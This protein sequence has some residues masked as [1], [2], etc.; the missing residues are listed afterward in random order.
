MVGR[1]A[2]IRP[3]SKS[4]R[5]ARKAVLSLHTEDQRSQL[6]QRALYAVEHQKGLIQVHDTENET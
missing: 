6:R 2:D 5:I 1:K 4:V 3:L